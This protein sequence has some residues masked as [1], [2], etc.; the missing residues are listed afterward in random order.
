MIKQI[1]K[2]GKAW[3]KA[4]K[5]FIEKSIESG[6]IIIG[7]ESYP[8]G[9]CEICKQWKYLDVDHKISRGRGGSN[10]D[11]NLQFLCRDCHS[12]KHN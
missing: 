4:R 6:R 10:E 5:A 7:F 9:R 11:D 3:L 1:G 12:E 8:E 2:K